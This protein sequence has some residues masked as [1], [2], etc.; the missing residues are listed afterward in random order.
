MTNSIVQFDF[1]GTNGLIL[2][3]LCE[4]ETNRE[5]IKKLEYSYLRV[6]KVLIVQ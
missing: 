2:G 6:W 1:V 3:V 4:R 5:D